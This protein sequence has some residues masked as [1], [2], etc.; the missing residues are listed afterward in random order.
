MLRKIFDEFGFLTKEGKV[1]VN[2]GFSK[3]VK[4]IFAT[5]TSQED[6]MVINSIL[7]SLI[8]KYSSELKAKDL[9]TNQLEQK[10][11]NNAQIIK[12]PVKMQKQKL[13]DIPP[14]E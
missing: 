8:D 12:F 14:T 2:D 10:T 6:I 4:N 3:E 13:F 5:A 9:Q 11:K 7:K 1:F